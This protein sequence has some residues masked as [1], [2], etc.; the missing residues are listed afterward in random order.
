MSTEEPAPNRRTM[1][2]WG[3][4]SPSLATIVP[5]DDADSVSTV[6][7]RADDRG[8][9]ARGM[10]RSYGDA[11]QNAGGVVVD[12]L[13]A[14]GISELDLENGVVTAQA[15]TSIHELITWL[16]PMGWFV[17]VTPGTRY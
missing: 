5:L 12:G 13:A 15:G 14:S 8:V 6:V 1:T 11:A 17:P 16:V 4:T 3:R 2:G 10:G 9:I 7:K